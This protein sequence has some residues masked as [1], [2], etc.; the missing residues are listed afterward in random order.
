MKKILEAMIKLRIDLET[1]RVIGDIQS[2]DDLKKKMPINEDDCIEDKIIASW[3]E[4]KE[5]VKENLGLTSLSYNL[6]IKPME[7]SKIEDKTIYL[8]HSIDG[9]E[10]FIERRYFLLIQGAILKLFQESY[11]L[12]FE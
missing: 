10:E 11:R 5:W 12:V 8:K 4:I 7:I 1:G 6:W 2:I 3:D 9:A